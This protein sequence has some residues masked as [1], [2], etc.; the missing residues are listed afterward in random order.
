MEKEI[1][2]EARLRNNRLYRAI[3][4]VYPNVSVF[5]KSGGFQETTV[6]ALLNLKKWPLIKRGEHK[7]EYLKICVKIANFFGYLPEVLFPLPLYSLKTVK[8]EKEFFF[9]E[10]P[11]ILQAQYL[12]EPETPRDIL[13]QKQ[14]KVAVEEALAT[15]TPREELVLKKH[16]GIDGDEETFE[17]IGTEFGVCPQRINQIEKNAFRKLR[18]VSKSKK[19]KPFIG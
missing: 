17:E 18:H 5:C 16:F 3:F 10:L 14:L 13:A 1:R 12:P 8:V 4:D 7:G 6:G 15:L 11:G 9:A 2:V 19:L